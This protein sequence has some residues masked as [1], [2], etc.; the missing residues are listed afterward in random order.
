MFPGMD[1][2]YAGPAQHVTDA[3]YNLDDLQLIVICL[4]RALNNLSTLDK[5]TGGDSRG[6]NRLHGRRL[7]FR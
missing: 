3:S 2:L 6:V 5:P 7:R 4:S 1:L